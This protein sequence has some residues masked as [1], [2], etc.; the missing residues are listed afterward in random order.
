MNICL[1]C[2]RVFDDEEADVI[3]DDPSPAGVSLPSGYYEYLCCP[4]CGSDYYEEAVKCLLCGEYVKE[5]NA[6]GDFCKDCAADVLGRMRMVLNESF[7]ETEIEW[8]K[9]N[10]EV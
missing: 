3:R 9:E 10:W 4:D 8:L 5:D 1:D 2:G 6:I 7:T